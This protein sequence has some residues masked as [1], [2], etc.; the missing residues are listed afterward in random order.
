VG[1]GGGGGR[2][3]LLALNPFLQDMQLEVDR[4][5]CGIVPNT[6]R[7]NGRPPYMTDTTDIVV[8]SDP[9]PCVRFTSARARATLPVRTAE[10]RVFISNCSVQMYL[11]PIVGG[12]KGAAFELY[13][14]DGGGRERLE[15]APV[16]NGNIEM[17]YLVTPLTPGYH[18]LEVSKSATMRPLEVAYFE[19]LLRIPSYTCV[20]VYGSSWSWR[21]AERQH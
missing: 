9:F 15:L 3:R 18:T 5:S 14:I 1:A 19:V 8:E 2:R 11:L 4:A 13:N 12:A 6:D 21:R 16:L 17:Y 20:Y 10:G 7:R